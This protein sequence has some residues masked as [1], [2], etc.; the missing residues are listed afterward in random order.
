M[1]R[2]VHETRAALR[3]EQRFEYADENVKTERLK[4]VRAAL[5]HR[6]AIRAQVRAERRAVDSRPPAEVTAPEPVTI[7][8][9]DIGPFVHYP[10][11]PDDIRA[12]LSLLPPGACDGLGPV[13]LCLEPHRF[14]EQQALEGRFRPDPFVGRFGSGFLP[15]VYC[16]DYFGT[17]WHGTPDGPPRITLHAYVYDPADLRRRGLAPLVHYLRLHMLATLVHEVAHHFDARHRRA[18]GRWRMDEKEKN[19]LYAEQWE[20]E[21]T[22]AVVVPYL[23]KTYPAETAELLAWVEEHGG[24]RTTLGFLAGDA[25]ATVKGG[26]ISTFN[27]LFSVH[28]A[29]EWLSK[30]VAGHEGTVATRLQFATD[31][32]YAGRYDEALTILGRL[33]T[34]RPK[35]R[36]TRRLVADIYVHQERYAE[37]RRIAARLCAEQPNDTRSLKVLADA[38]EGLEAW[39]PLLR[40]ASRLIARHR[41]EP[42]EQ[43]TPRL[44]RT[45]AYLRIGRLDD[46][47]AE[48]VHLERAETA[49]YRRKRLA[50]FR[51]AVDEARA[52]MQVAF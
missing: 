48:L 45:L 12:V 3:R 47:D 8:V 23:E 31:L 52:C 33:L 46:A 17:Y 15:G 49:R 6:D 22:Q 38:L 27:G 13:T 5:R 20:Q 10:G 40:A 7:L 50:A 9:R 1:S 32:H 2:S 18:R 36:R 30:G 37:A 39:R 19:E 44:Q 28:A 35:L 16:A 21:W 11:S 26:R 4:G 42:R 29:V 51:Q 41:T 43:F 25:R 14:R 24:L 34:R